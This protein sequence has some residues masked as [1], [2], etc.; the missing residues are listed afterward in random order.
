M[1]GFYI[2]NFALRLIFCIV[3]M[4]A[5]WFGLQFIKCNLI[6]HEPMTFGAFDIVIPLV[7]GIAEALTWKPKD[8]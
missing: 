3:G 5:L 1:K 6:L 4:F 8:K 7:G 2:E